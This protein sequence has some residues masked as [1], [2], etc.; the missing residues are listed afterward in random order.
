[1]LLSAYQIPSVKKIKETWKHDGLQVTFCN[2]D[3][4]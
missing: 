2:V 3:F 1:M 4:A